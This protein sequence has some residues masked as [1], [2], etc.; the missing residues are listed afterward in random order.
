MGKHTKRKVVWYMGF[1]IRRI[2][3]GWLVEGKSFYKTLKLAKIDIKLWYEG[4]E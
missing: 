2:D 4:K 1:D 3:G